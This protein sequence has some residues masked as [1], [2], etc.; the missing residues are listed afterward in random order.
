MNFKTRLHNNERLIGTMLTLPSPEIAEMISKCGYDWFFIDGEHGL[1]P[2]MECQR[3]LQAVAGRCASLIRVPENTEAELKRALDIGADGII[4]PRVNTAEEAQQ[5]VR[6]C[7]YP[8]VGIR[9]VGLGRAHGYGLDFAEYMETANQETLVVVQ[10][11]D[12]EAVENIDSIVQ[13]EGIDAVFIGPYDLS[14]SMNK[15][16]QI[17]DPEVMDAIERVTV[18]CLEN[19]IPLG[20]FGVSADSVQPYIE[21]GYNLICAG[22]DAGFVTQGAGQIIE[23]LK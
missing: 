23:N 5:I 7:K 9:G 22:V 20:Y 19:K 6:W 4:A 3:L 14:A 8:P 21:R 16:G 13:V 10:A 15:M 2:I 18:A 17:D 12:I 11:E 1:L